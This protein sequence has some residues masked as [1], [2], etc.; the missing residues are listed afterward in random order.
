MM[1]NIAL[2]VATI[3]LVLF[4]TNLSMFVFF[5]VIR[6]S[7]ARKIK[8]FFAQI[9]RYVMKVHIPFALVGTGLVLVH[10]VIMLL[11]HPLSILG[12]KKLSG[13]MALLVLGIHLYSGYLKYKRT[14]R[15]RQRFHVIMAFTLI[16][17]ILIHIILV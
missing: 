17:M 6:H 8:V 15:K 1:I 5:R 4:L 2:T 13:I 3:V 12:L 16:S 9:A 14:S 10:A 11:Y 7:K